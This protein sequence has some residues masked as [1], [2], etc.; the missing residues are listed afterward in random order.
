MQ[1]ENSGQMQFASVR[2]F[3]PAWVGGQAG[4]PLFA[5]ITTPAPT[6]EPANAPPARLRAA[7]RRGR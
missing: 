3:G 2:G 1:G 5:G 7:R 6:F 4:D